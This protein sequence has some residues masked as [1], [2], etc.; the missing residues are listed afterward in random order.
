MMYK[1]VGFWKESGLS[2]QKSIY[3]YKNLKVNG[4]RKLPW[5]L[6]FY[7]NN[8]PSL[9]NA[10][11]GFDNC[12]ISDDIISAEQFRTDGEWIWSD[13][14]IHYYEEHGIDLP[15]NFVKHI[16]KKFLPIPILF[17][18]KNFFLRGELVENIS[19]SLQQEIEQN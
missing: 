17:L 8:S 13:H 12:L 9:N 1:K 7:I 16:K 19:N 18:I 6:F 3:D 11:F 2:N 14:I 5:K 10:R 4:K 15:K